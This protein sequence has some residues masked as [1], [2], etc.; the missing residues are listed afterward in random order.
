MEWCC[1]PRGEPEP[2][3]IQ[4]IRL[5]VGGSGSGPVE[6]IRRV[7]SDEGSGQPLVS[8]D[9]GHAVVTLCD[10]V[11]TIMHPLVGAFL[12][13]QDNYNTNQVRGQVSTSI[14]LFYMYYDEYRVPRDGAT[15]Q[16]AG[17]GS[18]ASSR[19]LAEGAWFPAPGARY[20]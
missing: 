6:C 14:W 4:G 15:F 17:T 5:A 8:G 9:A 3:R 19:C 13:R 20:I 18:C 7:G 12:C 11:A 16:D 2:G 1:G 10:P